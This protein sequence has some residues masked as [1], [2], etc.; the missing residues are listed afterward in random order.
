MNKVGSRRSIIFALVFVIIGFVLSQIIN[1]AYL[2]QVFLTKSGKTQKGVINKV[3]ELSLN[4]SLTSDINVKDETNHIQSGVTNSKVI[5]LK[6]ILALES[7]FSQYQLAYQHAATLNESL[8]KAMI[9]KIKAL[10]DKHASA[11]LA[12]IY[13]GRYVTIDADNAVKF[14][15]SEYTGSN[16]R[17]LLHEIFHQWAIIDP[18]LASL[19]VEQLYPE[20]IKYDIIFSMVSH[21]F[22]KNSS[23]IQNLA[24]MLP[25]NLKER[26]RATVARNKGS[27]AYFYYYLQMDK[28]NK[29][30]R[31]GLFSA[32][33][34]WAQ[35]DPLAALE[36]VQYLADSNEKRSA[37]SA[38]LR[39]LMN[40][41]LTASI[42]LAIKLDKQGSKRRQNRLSQLLSRIAQTNGEQAMLLA[43]ENKKYLSR[44][45]KSNILASWATKDPVAAI[46]YWRNNQNSINKNQSYSLINAY[47]QAFPL[48]ALDLVDE[49]NLENHMIDNITSMIA[50]D[51]PEIAEQLL[52]SQENTVY[53]NKLITSIINVKARED[54][55]AAKDW[56][57]QFEGEEIYKNANNQLMGE[58]INQDPAG[59]A[60]ELSF[61]S[62]NS[63]YLLNSL[64]NSWY[65]KESSGVNAWVMALD[66]TQVRDRALEIL[67]QQVKQ[68]DHQ[69]ALS[70]LNEISD[71]HLAMRIENQI[72]DQYS[73]RL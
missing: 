68:Y 64:I 6:D 36:H 31:Q 3:N 8:T 54:L 39:Y 73:N 24:N 65:D 56:L 15:L 59:A 43:D 35:K 42:D 2:T 49:F 10:T 5:E 40:K 53:R 50:R 51:R 28:T 61:D 33:H 67:I 11:G 18:S 16:N 21:F 62:S 20:K 71:E 25:I 13:F 19:G 52:V 47:A 32:L 26:L 70:L 63:S 72:K 45:D 9:I 38:I 66:N 7:E 23:E 1:Q 48:K 12:P 30:R 44:S 41:D 4:P 37:E 14:Y 27:E 22:F 29:N 58:W 69:Q 60:S 17:A 46:D 34:D 55:K 57:Q